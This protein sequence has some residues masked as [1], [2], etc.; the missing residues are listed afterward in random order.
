MKRSSSFICQQCG[1]NSPQWLGRCPNCQSWNSFV[2]TTVENKTIGKKVSS[3][4]RSS[5][6]PKIISEVEFKNI[7]R[8]STGLLELDR[9]LGGGIVPGSAIL[10]TG[11]P[12]IGKSTLL[13]QVCAKLNGLYISGEESVY[14]V[15]IRAERLG[16]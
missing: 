11:E 15:K 5:E 3:G 16:F 12:G 13:L 7:T 10:L 2:E 8:F 4:N 1:Y 14:Q 9:V 6:K